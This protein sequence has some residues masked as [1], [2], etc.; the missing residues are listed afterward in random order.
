MYAGVF[1]RCFSGPFLTM[2]LFFLASRSK[3]RALSLPHTSGPAL[4]LE[5]GVDAKGS[6]RQWNSESGCV[7]LYL[8]MG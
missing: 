7:C 5:M 3:S 6:V 4:G 2:L 1:G 8:R